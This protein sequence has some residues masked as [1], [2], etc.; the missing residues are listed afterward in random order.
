MFLRYTHKSLLEKYL[1]MFIR[2][3][4]SICCGSRGG[5]G[6]VRWLESGK[7]NSNFF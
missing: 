1:Y 4:C 6:I 2:S 7:K 3:L 5:G